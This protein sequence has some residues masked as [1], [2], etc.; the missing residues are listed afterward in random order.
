MADG[1]DAQELVERIRRAR[2]WAAEEQRRMELQ[3]ADP[4]S[5]DRLIASF[6]VVSLSAV[7]GVLD[8]ILEP[9]VHSDKH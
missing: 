5:A 3:V 9:G 2:D 4:D 1:I 8:E 7:R 6:E